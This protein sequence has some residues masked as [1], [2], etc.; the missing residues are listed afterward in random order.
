[1]SE[2][3]RY[4]WIT[5]DRPLTALQ[6]D[7]VD[8]LSSHIEVS[9]THAV[10]EYNYGNFKHDA[11]EILHEYFDGFLY[12]ANW[13]SPQLAFRFPHGILPRDLIAKYDFDDFVTFTTHKKYDILAIQFGEMEA[14]NE[15]EDYE[16]GQ[17]LPIREEIMDGDLRAIYIVWLAAQ[18]WLVDVEDDD[19]SD[20]VDGDWLIRSI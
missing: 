1:L 17:L 5:V 7:E 13:G 12:W 19:D 18:R 3:Q 15:W 8:S 9:S 14:P 4:E 10:V 2:Y 16:L 20:E 6:V 11:I